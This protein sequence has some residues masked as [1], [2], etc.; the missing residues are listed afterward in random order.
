MC[1]AASTR[2]CKLTMEVGGQLQC[3]NKDRWCR[4][5]TES[6][7]DGIWL[8]E[9]SDEEIGAQVNDWLNEQNGSFDARAFR[10]AF[11]KMC[12]KK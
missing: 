8:H 6:R 10:E 4:L 2:T 1:K 12:K 3:T 9:A 7:G 11:V 5:Q